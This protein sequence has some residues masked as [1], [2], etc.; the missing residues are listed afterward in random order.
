MNYFVST[1]E[2]QQLSSASPLDL[3]IML[4]GAAIHDYEHPYN[5][6]SIPSGF[7]NPY[8]INTKHP[9]ALR[10]NGTTKQHNSIDKSPLENHHVSAAFVVLKDANNNFCKDFSPEDYT[11]FRERMISMI[12]AT[13]MAVHFQD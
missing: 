9:L 2:F 3:A 12:L 1:C 11:Y 5:W 7:N 8:L 4:I 6:N 10:Y 13:D